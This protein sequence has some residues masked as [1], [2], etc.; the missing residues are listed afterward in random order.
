VGQT[1]PG[2]GAEALRRARDELAQLRRLF[3]RAH[4]GASP[5]W[6]AA[7]QSAIVRA[8]RSVREAGGDP[9]EQDEPARDPDDQMDG[10]PRDG[11]DG[12]NGS[13]SG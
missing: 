12:P 13:G 8:E 2:E 6:V 7:A 9:A 5:E 3:D 10:Q 11:P 4:E 1:D